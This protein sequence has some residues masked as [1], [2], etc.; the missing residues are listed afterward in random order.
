M[1]AGFIF[2]KQNPLLK[3][4]VNAWAEKY[5]PSVGFAIYA[6]QLAVM[7]EPVHFMAHVLRQR[8]INHALPERP[9]AE[10]WLRLYRSHAQIWIKIGDAVP[11]IWGDG[12]SSLRLADESRRLGRRAKQHPEEIKAWT[13]KVGQKRLTR[14]IWRTA[15][16]GRRLYLDHLRGIYEMITGDQPGDQDF[17]EVIATTPEIQFFLEATLPCVVEYEMLPIALLRRARAGDE[18][19]IERLVRID[20]TVLDDKYVKRWRDSGLG[21]ERRRK[22]D[23]IALWMRE[24]VGGQLSMQGVKESIAGW[25]AVM[26]SRM[27]TTWSWKGLHKIRIHSGEILEL[28]NAV[29]R[30]R[31]KPFGAMGVDEDLF[32]LEP[33]SWRQAVS[34][35]KKAWLSGLPAGMRQTSAE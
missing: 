22:I 3:L 1:R 11:T 10:Q 14:L 20:H 17:G 27:T 33:E 21:D 16:L 8:K 12:E 30:D 24:G 26:A 19:S 31:G 25:I 18:K 13:A 35:K 2:D 6:Q 28:F 7:A 29:A 4:H 9:P 5:N 32:Y 23:L 15:R 34:K